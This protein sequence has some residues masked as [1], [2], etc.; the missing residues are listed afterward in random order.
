MKRKTEEQRNKKEKTGK[1]SFIATALQMDEALQAIATSAGSSR[2]TAQSSPRTSAGK[3][4]KTGKAPGTEA[5]AAAAA[6]LES[7]ASPHPHTWPAR[8][9]DPRSGQT[10]RQTDG[11]IET[12]RD[13]AAETQ[14]P[15]VEQKDIYISTSPPRG[16]TS[17]G[18]PAASSHNPKSAQ[19]GREFSGM[20]TYKWVGHHSD[21]PRCAI[22]P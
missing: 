19:Q 5:K 18:Q 11:D 22:L 7:P 9:A 6:G 8:V 10:V 14:L 20:Y 1:S 16:A 17:P 13:P 12:Q 3:T 21:D 15:Q 4:N 2:P